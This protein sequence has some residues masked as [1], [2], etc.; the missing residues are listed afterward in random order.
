MAFVTGF[1][2]P[3]YAAAMPMLAKAE[4]T[5]QPHCAEMAAKA[6]TVEKTSLPAKPCCEKSCQCVMSLSSNT[7]YPPVSE[8]VITL[9]VRSITHPLSPGAALVSRV[10]DVPLTPPKSLSV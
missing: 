8:G 1:V 10:D 6:S 5:S 9:S 4:Q 7:F 2:L 3:S